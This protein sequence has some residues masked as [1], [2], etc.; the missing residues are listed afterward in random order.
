[1]EDLNRTFKVSA[2]GNG[3]LNLIFIEALENS[4][5]QI[6]QAELIS[7]EII[8]IFDSNP[9]SRYRVFIDLSGIE[10]LPT[11]A[12]RCRKIYAELTKRGEAVKVAVAGL[13]LSYKV[14]INFISWAAGKEMKWF[15][16]REEALA[17]LEGK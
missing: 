4:E 15:S 14:I 6:R 1:M 2:D 13:N 17:W 12:S 11:L 16:D 8:G 5:G 9:A 7:R 10:R 3:L